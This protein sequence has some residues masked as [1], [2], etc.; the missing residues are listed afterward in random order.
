MMQLAS[1]I[2]NRGHRLLQS[3]EPLTDSAILR[4]A[5]SVFATAKHESRSARYAYVPTIEVL[6][7][8]QKQGFQPFMVCQAGTRVP[9]K[10]EF[11][12]HMLRLRRLGGGN[13]DEV[14]DIILLNSHDGSSAY[15][16]LAGCFRFVCANGMVCGETRADIRVRHSG[17]VVDNVIEGAFRVLDDFELIDEQRDGMKRLTLNQGEQQAFAHAALELRYGQE[18][19]QPWRAPVTEDAVLAARRLEDTGPSLWTTFNRVQENLLQ[20][21]LVGR[22]AHNRRQTTRA[23]AGIDQNVKLNRALWTLA[24]EMKRLKA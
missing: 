11:T 3:N 10:S 24:N 16:M 17:N 12:K 22:S 5:P 23:V 13:T 21:G 4:V 1:K 2:A 9:G 14:N 8:L 20:G 15:Q 7:G 19:G 18:D 6:H